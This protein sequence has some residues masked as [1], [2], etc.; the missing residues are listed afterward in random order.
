MWP[1][2]CPC[3]PSASQNGHTALTKAIQRSHCDIAKMLLKSGANVDLRLQ[4]RQGLLVHA[5]VILYRC[6]SFWV[7]GWVD[8][9]ERFHAVFYKM[10]QREIY[11]VLVVILRRY[12]GR[13]SALGHYWLAYHPAEIELCEIQRAYDSWTFVGYHYEDV[14]TLLVAYRTGGHL[15]S[16]QPELQIKSWWSC[17]YNV[18]W[19]KIIKQ[20]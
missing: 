16:S 19:T 3:A 9:W 20:R 12:F 1:L 17:C 14:T 18:G 15:L 11:L 13:C 5:R 7:R 8:D 6:C 2:S 10:W 4:V